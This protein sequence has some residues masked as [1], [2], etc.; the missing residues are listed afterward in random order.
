MSLLNR[1]HSPA[2]RPFTTLTNQQTPPSA[3][4]PTSSQQMTQISRKF[5]H[6]AND[7]A[8]IFLKWAI[9]K[10][11]ILLRALSSLLSLS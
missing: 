11:A 7:F 10:F 3:F 2:F 5:W 6:L 9:D 8:Q 1:G 4:P